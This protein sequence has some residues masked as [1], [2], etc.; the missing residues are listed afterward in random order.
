MKVNNN[1][2]VNSIDVLNKLTNLEL[3]IKISYIISKN[4][5]KIDNELKVYN[6]EREKLIDKY[7][8]RD[9]EGKLKVREDG[10]INIVDI[11]SWNKANNELLEIET[12]IDIQT[13]DLDNI[14]LDINITPGELI[15]VDYMFK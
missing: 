7:G 13:I 10:N 4:I 1:K 14:D 3:P 9:A 8:E 6:K 5:I 2:L 12:E 15:T 11:E